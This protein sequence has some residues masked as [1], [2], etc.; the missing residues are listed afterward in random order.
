[1]GE[2]CA[3]CGNLESYWLHDPSD[4][5]FRHR[6]VAASDKPE[7]ARNAAHL[8]MERWHAGICGAW[9]ASKRGNEEGPHASHHFSMCDDLTDI[10]RRAYAAGRLAGQSAHGKE[11]GQLADVLADTQQLNVTMR[12]ERD[13]LRVRLNEAERLL[14]EE[15]GVDPCHCSRSAGSS[16]PAPSSRRTCPSRDAMRSTTADMV[17]PRRTAETVR[18]E[19]EGIVKRWVP[20]HMPARQGLVDDI[21][22]SLLNARKLE[23][24]VAA[25][26]IRRALADHANDRQVAFILELMAAA[27]ERQRT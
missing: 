14:R 4:D 12:A 10:Y 6:F 21:T 15:V 23:R 8:Q 25:G 27:I 26:F 18:A 1:M 20:D 2:T 13:Q 19:A 24:D 17:P 3:K 5:G 7:E 22:A 9:A 11:L 16:V